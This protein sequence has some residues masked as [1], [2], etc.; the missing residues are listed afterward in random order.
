MTS[1][2][3]LYV[4]ASFRIP[5]TVFDVFT[6]ALWE[7]G[8]LGC[9]YSDQDADGEIH[10]TAFFPQGTRPASV[11]ERLIP[12]LRA[13]DGLDLT[14]TTWDRLEEVDWSA[15]WR[16]SY[17]PIVVGDRLAILPAWSRA[18]FAGRAI[19]KIS[20]RMAF[21]TGS[22]ESTR[23]CLDALDHM[24][25][26]GCAVADVGTGSGILA[27]AAT[28]LGAV[29]VDACDVD[30]VAL[31]NTRHN[32]RMNRVADRVNIYEGNVNSFSDHS[33]YDIILAN[34]V[35]DPIREQLDDMARRLKPA[36]L[37]LA[38]GL[39]AD[40]EPSMMTSIQNAGLRVK[41]RTILQEWMMLTLQKSDAPDRRES[42]T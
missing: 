36:G 14:G 31:V 19:V 18:R 12:W 13:T 25:T 24:V 40:Q 7:V 15:L 17:S 29:S 28:K 5:E 39:L 37:I 3:I 6:G 34:I 8:T 4:T 9:E 30:A 41:T 20:P 42:G 23:L 32:V 2:P 35:P 26:E 10:V 16:T 22:H 1:P 11:L 38:S 21:G 27:I 33:R